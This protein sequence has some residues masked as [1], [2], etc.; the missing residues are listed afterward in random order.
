MLR[1]ALIEWIKKM[2]T[3]KI[4]RSRKNYGK[5]EREIIEKLELFFRDKGYVVVTHARL[6]I[7]WGT[8]LS[9]IDLVL[10][11]NNK[12]TIIEVKSDH[13]NFIRAIDQIKKYSNYADYV[14]VATEKVQT[15]NVENIDIGLI[16]V[17]KQ[18]SIMKPPLLIKSVPS[19]E[20]I[21]ALPKES[22]IEAFALNKKFWKMNKN[23][24][25][26]H[27]YH[28]LDKKILKDNVKKIA[29]CDF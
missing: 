14:Y 15:L 13:D 25:V 23:D 22:L 20:S 5:Y 10:L 2:D 6:N 4:L 21:F 9:D 19:I 8:T 18:I 28:N 29:Y 3:S 7:S 17:N 1:N 26:Y 27:I 24:L 12:I 16:I 11:R